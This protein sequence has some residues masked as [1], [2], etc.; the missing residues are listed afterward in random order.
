MEIATHVKDRALVRRVSLY[1]SPPPFQSAADRV[2]RVGGR[3]ARVTLL[4]D[5]AILTLLSL[6]LWSASGT[7]TGGISGLSALLLAAA[8]M[9]AFAASSLYATVQHP[10]RD[11]IEESR[12]V[13]VGAL[14]GVSG[15]AFIST[16]VMGEVLDR[17][18]VLLVAVWAVVAAVTTFMSRRAI[19]RRA[20]LADPDRILIVGAGSTAQALARSIDR[21]PGMCVVGFIDND[22]LPLDPVL[23]SVPVFDDSSDLGGAIEATGATRLIVAFSRRS[24][25]DVLESIRNSRFGGIPVSVV[26]RYFEI[27]P[28]HARLS[29][30]DGVPL[31]DLHSARLSR[32]A[33]MTKRALDIVLSAFGL[34]LLSPLLLAVALLVKL[35]SRGPVI[36]GQMRTGQDGR[37]FRM[38]KFRTMVKDA[39][40]R[41]MSLADHNDMNGSGPLFKI[42]NDPRV[43]PVGRF[44]RRYS[45]DEIPQLFNVLAG[46]MSLVGPRPFVI[47]EDDQMQ[48]WSR[49]RLDLVPGITGL[50]QVKGRNDVPYEEMIRLDYL[51]VTNW[52]VWWDL[53]LMLQTIPRVVTGRGAS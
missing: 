52:S 41:R 21:S 15:W 26:P 50:W 22:P 4:S 36:F 48:G 33:R 30:I 35:T 2:S 10:E 24:A 38:W 40:A 39:E 37:S 9:T 34:L 5:A 31:L 43:T 3:T 45:I 6:S 32:G 25:S 12:R 13:C 19:R 23:G 7:L 49:R 42:R 8:V 20:V 11:A 29:E 18:I 27:T 47:H 53:R 16:V 46:S 28:S 14:V 51:Y 17:G 44:L 1:G